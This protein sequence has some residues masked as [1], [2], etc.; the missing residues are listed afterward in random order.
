MHL[1]ITFDYHTTTRIKDELVE[2][3][4]GM[5][6]EGDGAGTIEYGGGP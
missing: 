5:E 3:A 6:P 4:E 2:F 1:L